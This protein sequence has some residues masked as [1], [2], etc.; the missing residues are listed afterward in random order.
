MLLGMKLRPIA[1][2]A[3]SNFSRYTYSNGSSFAD[4]GSASTME[5]SR[6]P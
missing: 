4:G 3:A 5:D 1:L 6:L 2:L